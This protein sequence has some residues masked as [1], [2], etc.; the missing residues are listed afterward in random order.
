MKIYRVR[1]EWETVIR[2][3][4][5]NH[6]MEQAERVIRDGDDEH[7]VVE[8]TEIKSQTELPSGWNAK[9]RPWGEIDPYDRTLGE[10]LPLANSQAQPPKVG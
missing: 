6:A 4:D 7:D 8:A 9:C 10:I 2:A 5:E 3:K 1:I